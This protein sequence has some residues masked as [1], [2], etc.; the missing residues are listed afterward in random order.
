MSSSSDSALTYDLYEDQ[1]LSTKS[2][3]DDQLTITKSHLYII[4][5]EKDSYQVDIDIINMSK[6]MK[7]SILS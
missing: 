7:Y 2:L 3:C 6:L 4:V 5:H 1:R